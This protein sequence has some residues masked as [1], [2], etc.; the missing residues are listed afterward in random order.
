MNIQE[1]EKKILELIVDNA[2]KL[3]YVISVYDGGETT[4]IKSEDRA[5]ILDALMTTDEDVMRFYS[6]DEK[7][8]FKRRGS[9]N[10][11]YGNDGYDVIAD[12]SD[13]E[14]ME[15]ILTPANTFSD[16]WQDNQIVGYA[17]VKS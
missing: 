16:E 7:G 12:H 3:G 14:A 11:I 10:L 13:N 4:V 2:L 5:K 9:V 6:A 17:M 1:I 8:E 15:K